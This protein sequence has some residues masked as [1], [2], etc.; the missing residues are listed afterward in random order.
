MRNN[1]TISAVIAAAAVLGASCTREIVVV[2][3]PATTVTSTTAVVETTVP[4]TTEPVRYISDD[5]LFL[6]AVNSETSLGR[7]LT[8]RE[9]LELGNTMCEFLRA[10][11]TTDELIA[12]ILEAGNSTGVGEDM[13]LDYAGVAGLAVAFLCPDQGWKI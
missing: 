5:E 11:G 13:M 12:M 9:L 1:L 7:T 3:E 8:D 2:Q 6:N 4:E 10:G